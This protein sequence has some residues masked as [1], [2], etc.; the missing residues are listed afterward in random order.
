M[1][2]ERRYSPRARHGSC[3]APKSGEELTMAEA[4]MGAGAT[5]STSRRFYLW[6]AASCFII[7]VVGF[8]PTYWAPLVKGSFK[9]EPMVHIHGMLMFGW[10]TFFVAQT[11][12]VANGRT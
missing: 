8:A 3:C 6:M 9:A 1:P 7:A 12:L 4:V 10:V 11:W 5:S 2:A